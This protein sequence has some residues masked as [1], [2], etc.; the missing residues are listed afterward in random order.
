VAKGEVEKMPIVGTVARR[1][2]QFFFDRHD[3]PARIRQAEEVDAALARGESVAIYPEGT[4]TEFA[5]IRPFQLGAFKAAIDTQRPI[6]PVA[7]RGARKIL[8]DR[9]YL[10]RWG[11]VTVTFGPLIRP[12]PRAGSDWREMIR[13]RDETREVIALNTGELLL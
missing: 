6:C 2:G 12:D 8:P 10:P 11:V 4:F 5:G 3:S 9:S 7:I 1:M 13:L